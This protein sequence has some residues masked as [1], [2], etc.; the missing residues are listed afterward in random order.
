MTGIFT[1]RFWFAYLRDLFTV[2]TSAT[3]AAP[4]LSLGGILVAPAYMAGT[5]AVLASV[6]FLRQSGAM[7]A[8][9]VISFPFKLLLFVLVDGWALVVGTLASSFYG[10]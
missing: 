5:F 1:T 8:G 3:R 7:V 10:P 2:A 6:I 9:L 4:G